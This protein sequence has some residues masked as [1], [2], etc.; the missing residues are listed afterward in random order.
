MKKTAIITAITLLI[1]VT[2]WAGQLRD[3]SWPM[4]QRLNSELV[5][6]QNSDRNSPDYGAIMCPRCSLYHTRA[7]EAVFPLAYEY[8]QT[9]DKKR[10]HQALILADWLIDQQLESGAWN[11]TPADWKATST[12]QLMMMLMAWPIVEKHLSKSDRARWLSAMEKAADYLAENISMKAA[13]INYLCSTAGTLAEAYALFGKEIYRTKAREFAH[14]STAKMNP[15]WFIEGESDLI[16]GNRHGVDIGYN[17]EMSVWGLARYAQ[18]MGDK[19]VWDAARHSTESHFHFIYPD[20]MM[21]ASVGVRSNKWS[22]FGSG[23]SDGCAVM[24]ALMSEGHPEYIT[25]A[26]RNIGM[27]ERCFTSNGLVGNGPDYDAAMSESPCLYPTFT[28]AKSLAMAMTWVA[29]D[30]DELCP[31]PCDSDCNVFF[32]TLNTAIVR[33]GDFQGTVTSYNY[34]SMGG[35]RSNNMYRPTGGTMSALWVDGYGLLQASSQTEYYR[36][37]PMHFLVVDDIECLTPRMEYHRDTLFYTNLF[38]Y[39]ATISIDS[40]R[41]GMTTVTCTGAL[42][43]RQHFWGGV[44]FRNTYTW[45]REGV[46]KE[47][48]ILH[49]TNDAPVTVIEPLICDDATSIKLIDSHNVEATRGGRTIRISCPD[50][51]IT[52]DLQAAPRYR[53]PFPALR[54][55]PMTITS[56]NGDCRRDK[57]TIIYR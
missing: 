26:V 20:G 13:V 18:V 51:E 15:E 37:E 53:Q 29:A 2:A 57:V 47:Y 4:L 54:A 43:D 28:K 55:I 45:T 22:V 41:A 56:E 31:L 21:E 38:D 6:L 39:D 25:A 50:H 23:T 12:D 3:A 44:M 10:L 14:I 27:V 48:E 24:F 49:Q 46:T 17:M 30:T 42:R 34:K 52:L 35:Y 32:H 9:G 7:A 33:R 40:T 16:K 5:K 1:G 36:W 19:T 8:S 11:E